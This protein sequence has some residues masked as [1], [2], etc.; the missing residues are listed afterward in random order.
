MKGWTIELSQRTRMHPGKFPLCGLTWTDRQSDLR[1]WTIQ[2]RFVLLGWFK[3]EETPMTHTQ[4]TPNKQTI[5]LPHHIYSLTIVHFVL[6]NI[7]THTHIYIFTYNNV[8]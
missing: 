7:Y 5:E 3:L 2:S 6:Q 4:K 1:Q 8:G